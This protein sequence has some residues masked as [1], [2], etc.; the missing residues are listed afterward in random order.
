MSG[1]LHGAAE[2]LAAAKLIH[3]RVGD[4]SPVAA[5]ILGSGLGK[6]ADEIESAT[7]ID[8]RDVPGFPAAT[9]AGHAG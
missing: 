5:I 6:L 7:A 3:D 8:Y 4:F 9:V 2:A 1:P